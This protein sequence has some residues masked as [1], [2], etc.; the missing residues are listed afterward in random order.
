MKS[1]YTNPLNSMQRMQ[2]SLLI[3]IRP[4]F[5]SAA[6]KKLFSVRRTLIHTADGVFFLDPVSN[7]GFEITRTGEYEPGMARI[8]RKH[9]FEGSTFVD[10]GANEGYFTVLG[11]ACC[12][13]AGTVLAIEPQMRL[14]DI[15]AENLRLNNIQ[16]VRIAN[17]AVTDHSGTAVL[18]LASDTNSGSSGLHRV[19]KYKVPTQDVKATT[20]SQLLSEERIQTVDLLK[21]DIEGFEYEALLGSKDLFKQQRVRALALELHPWILRARGKDIDDITSMLRIC[22]YSPTKEFES[23]WVPNS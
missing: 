7:L 23:V 2:Q 22:G 5:L 6:L 16:G 21:V 8:L 13:S 9:L 14:L 12:G 19:T 11:A 1:S 3:N 4:A 20:L 10:L 15:I 18:H 17:V